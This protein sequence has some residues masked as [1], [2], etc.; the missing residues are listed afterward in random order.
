MATDMIFETG[1]PQNVVAIE[2]DKHSHVPSADFLL[3]F[4]CV[5]EVLRERAESLT[6]VSAL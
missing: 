4:H 6:S 3:L 2:T 1:K 5:F